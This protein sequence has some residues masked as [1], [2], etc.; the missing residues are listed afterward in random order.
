[1][2]LSWFVVSFKK[3]K[4]VVVSRVLLFYFGG[5]GVSLFILLGAGGD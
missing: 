2:L 1:M 4:I 5:W 3:K